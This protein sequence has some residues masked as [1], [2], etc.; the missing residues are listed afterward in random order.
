MHFGHRFVCWPTCKPKGS[1]NWPATLLTPLIC[2][3]FWSPL[4]LLTLLSTVRS[5]DPIWPLTCW[6]D[7][8]CLIGWLGQITID[9]VYFDF[10]IFFNTKKILKKSWKIS[11]KIL[12][13]YDRS[14]SAC[15][16]ILRKSWGKN[17]KYPSKI[18]WILFFSKNIHQSFFQNNSKVIFLNKG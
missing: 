4:D 7:Q 10:S 3:P 9:F 12:Y 16:S 14:H 6:L 18:F 17:Y 13:A 5:A 15:G 11:K 8:S 1:C 2:W